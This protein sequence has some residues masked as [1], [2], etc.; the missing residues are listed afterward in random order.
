MKIVVKRTKKIRVPLPKQVCKV[1]NTD[2]KKYSRK[3]YKL[4]Y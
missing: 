4:E 1:Q 3:N 2:K